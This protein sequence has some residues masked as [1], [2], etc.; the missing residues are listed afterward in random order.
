MN[1][2][3]LNKILSNVW[4]LHPREVNARKAEMASLLKQQN[5]SYSDSK[6]IRLDLKA[7][8]ET[9]FAIDKGQSMAIA[10]VAEGSSIP[11]GSIAIMR[12]NGIIQKE[13]DMCTKGLDEYENELE[14]LGQNG[15]VKGVALEIH[16]PGG[17]A[18]GGD[19]FGQAISNFEK[20]FGKPLAVVIK[21]MAASA[22]Y[23]IA[24]QAPMIFVSSDTAEAGSIGTMATLYDDLAYLDQMGV[25]EIVVRATK[26]F[27]KNEEYYQATQG[28][29]IPLQK[30]VLDPLNERFINSIKKAR[31]G[32]LDLKTTSKTE[33]GESVPDIFTG[34]VYFGQDIISAGLADAMGGREEAFKYLEKRATELKKQNVKQKQEQQMLTMKDKNLE[35]LQARKTE[36]EALVQSSES[37]DDSNVELEMIGREIEYRNS[38]TLL[39]AEQA[40]VQ[41]LT[42]KIEATKELSEKLEQSTKEVAELTEKLEAA[43][44]LQDE[45]LAKENELS[46]AKK[47]IEALTEKEIAIQAEK[48]TT[49]AEY[50]KMK[51]FMVGQFGEAKVSALLMSEKSTDG[52]QPTGL[53]KKA[54]LSKADELAEIKAM[55]KAAKERQN[56]K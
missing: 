34:K 53:E 46:E 3:V 28:N 45:V 13:S 23:G 14:Y 40:K 47:A 19:V 10:S 49:E 36:L 22:A 35:Y 42:A 54:P 30:N 39:E 25:K 17:T 21:S 50:E 18:I 5:S 27:N 29:P 9:Y 37:G 52:S 44:K 4:A 51:K 38:K 31:R 8:T 15:N 41:D 26:S 48:E 7:R 16:S 55:A 56:T 11:K 32:K 2:T 24:S 6:E 20:K 43:N 12:I 33:D 1:H